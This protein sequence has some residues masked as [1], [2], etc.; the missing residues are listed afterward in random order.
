M[1]QVRIALAET[2]EV[3]YRL[4]LRATHGQPD[5]T[6]L[7]VAD[8]EVALMLEAACADVAVVAMEHG[9]LPAVAE[10]LLDEYQRLGVVSVDTAAARGGVYRL[11]PA[12]APVDDVSPA[13]LAAAIRSAAHDSTPWRWR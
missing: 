10:R 8:G 3:L 1:G 2:P 7:P 13:G 9:Q 12:L 6:L 5:L 11:R 4:V